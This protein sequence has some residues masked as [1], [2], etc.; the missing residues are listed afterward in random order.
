MNQFGNPLTQQMLAFAPQQQQMQQM[1]P[2]QGGLLGNAFGQQKPQD[3]YQQMA[4]PY[5]Q[6]AAQQLQQ[7]A[8]Q[9]QTPPDAN[10]MQM[11][12]MQ[13]QLQQ[14]MNMQQNRGSELSAMMGNS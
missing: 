10:Q 8:P 13:Q 3:Q 4:A 12:Q 11:Q 5:A 7:F 6:W 9:T 1:P 2:M 14:L